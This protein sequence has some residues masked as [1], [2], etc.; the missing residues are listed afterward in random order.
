MMVHLSFTLMDYRWVDT[1]D[2]KM[3]KR[4]KIKLLRNDPWS[5]FDIYGKDQAI[6]LASWCLL[7]RGTSGERLFNRI[8]MRVF[9][10]DI[11]WKH[12]LMKVHEAELNQSQQGLLKYVKSKF[13]SWLPE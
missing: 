7:N 2:L 13:M 10:E 5:F 4:Q 12:Q 3:N 6:S 11:S 9:F 1:K 8:E